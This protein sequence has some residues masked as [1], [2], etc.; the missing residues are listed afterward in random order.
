[1]YVH[2]AMDRGAAFLRV[3]RLLPTTSWTVYDRRGY[4]RSISGTAAT[5]SDHVDDLVDIVGERP[6]VLVG[7]S[8]GGTIA[9]AAAERRPDRVRAVVAFE[10]PL[11]WLD[12]WPRRGPAG[13]P[14][15]EDEPA[16]A[17]DRFMRRVAGEEVWAGLPEATRARRLEE[18]VALVAELTSVRQAPAYDGA[19]LPVPVVV[20]VG[21]TADDTR[22]RAARV[23]ADTLPL[24]ELH[25][26]P[27]VPHGVHTSHPERFAALVERALTL[28]EIPG[29]R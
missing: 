8:L 9:L 18:G 1:M 23:L 10:S 24:G 14:L 4:G 22:Q 25:V 21:S 12:W 19:T 6:C 26:V 27:D 15:E 5:I 3:T 7:H 28:G 11:S 2:G 17:V 29:G 20:G 13:G 16:V